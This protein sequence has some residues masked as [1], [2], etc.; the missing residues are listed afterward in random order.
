MMVV[1]LIALSGV[2]RG[3]IATLGPKS[4][5]QPLVGV[6]PNT[7]SWW[8]LASLPEIGESTAREIVAYRDSPRADPGAMRGPRADGRVFRSSVDL[9]AVRG[10]GP[11]TLHRAG[12][13]LR[14]D[15]DSPANGGP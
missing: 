2:V 13:Y 12:A 14:F 3:W 11:V 4:N 7:A 1:G 10:I 8:A 6:D 15:S 5:D 9:D